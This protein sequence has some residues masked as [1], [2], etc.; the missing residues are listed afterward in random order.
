MIGVGS[1][2]ANS[3]IGGSMAWVHDCCSMTRRGYAESKGVRV[4]TARKKT[5]E[6]MKQGR[7]DLEAQRAVFV[8]KLGVPI[9]PEQRHE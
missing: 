4:S 3:D 8:Q 5:A 7:K 1:A 6:L 2:A 9:P